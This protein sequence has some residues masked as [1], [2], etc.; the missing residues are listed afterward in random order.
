MKTKTL[1]ILALLSTFLLKAQDISPKVTEFLG[2]YD[3]DNVSEMERVSKEIIKIAPDNYAGYAFVGYTSVV[4]NDLVTAE[5]YMKAARNLNPVDGASYGISSYIQ[6]L[7]G[8]TSEAKKLMEFSFQIKG[9]DQALAATLGDINQIGRVSGIDMTTLKEIT[10]T[11]DANYNQS[12]A[13]MQQYYGCYQ[14]WSQGESCDLSQVNTYFS[15]LHPTNNMV[16]AI[17]GYYKAISYYGAQ[18]WSGAKEAINSYLNNPIVINAVD[19]GYSKAQSYYYL[20]EY[21]NSDLNYNEMLNS[22]NKGLKAL[23]EIE[24]PTN[25]KCQLLHKKV[26]ALASLGKQDEE[27]TVARQLLEEANKLEFLLMQSQANNTIG[28]Y[29][30]MSAQSDSRKKAF[31]YL[32]KAYS[33]AI[34]L[35]D[36]VLINTISGNYSIALWQQGRKEQAIEVGNKSFDFYKKQK[37]Y[38]GAQLTVNNLGFM[39]FI[40]EDYKNASK[41]FNKAVTITEKYSKDLTPAQQLQVMNE[42]SSAYGGLIMSY[43][44]LNDVASLFKIQDLNRSRLLR[45]KLNKNAK[46]QTISNAQKLLKSDEVLLYYSPGGPGEMIVSVITNNSASIGY[47]FPIDSWIAIKKQFINKINKKPNS[48]NGYVAKMNEEI[49]DGH[50]ISYNSKE[51][52]FNAKDYEQFVSLTREL[53]QSN[54]A[55]LANLQKDFLKQWYRFLISPIESKIQGKKTLIISGEASLIFLPFEAFVSPDNKYLIETYNIKYIP[56]VSVWA[57]LQNRI[58]IDDR[59]ELLAMGGA[60]Y[61]DP[62]SSSS[63]VRGINDIYDIQSQITQKIASSSNISTELKALGFGGANYL[64]GTLQEVQNLQ[65][66]IPTATILINQDM[67]ESDIKRLSTSGELSKYK[68]IHIASHGF[69]LDNIPELSGVMMTQPNGGDGNE[70]MFLLSHE[71]AKLNLNADLMVLSAC[72]TALGK[73]YRG[74]GVNG[75][76]SAILTAG[77]NNT[78]LSLWPVNDAGTM[79][80]MS[81]VYDNL[82]NQKQEVDEAVNNAKRRLLKGDAGEKFAA[83][84]IWAPFVLNGK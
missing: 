14:Y 78:L 74:E 12:P 30:L 67:K 11:A 24:F 34:K 20:T 38:S 68:Y 50:I 33:Q 79:I 62:K 81:L 32:Q 26:L 80:F 28:D 43:Q 44:K 77:A 48:I 13:M 5:K 3:N 1:L 25:L 52:A 40:S 84:Y 64:P 71:I 53:L 35:N 9:S 18:N 51:Q 16:M 29:Y 39:S 73:I 19:I 22:A 7:K 70:D 21:D 10:K 63:S 41:L 65:K 55:S 8:N 46:A 47:N 2:F 83:P 75:L 15:G 72:E 23:E 82:Y 37:D 66:I 54:E 17:T 4:E 45:Q 69:A 60:T 6:F 49:I 57:S 36:E 56:S 59:K 31:S 42:H 76:N 27:L 58:Y 61:Q